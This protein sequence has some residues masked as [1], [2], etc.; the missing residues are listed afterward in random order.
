MSIESRLID[1]ADKTDTLATQVVID[2]YNAHE[3][4]INTKQ[5][6]YYKRDSH[7]KVMAFRVV[8][9]EY[10]NHPKGTIYEVKK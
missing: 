7:L 4:L 10:L 2:Y 5:K 9:Y 1:L 8:E 3:Y 6:E